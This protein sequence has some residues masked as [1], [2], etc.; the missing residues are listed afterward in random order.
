MAHLKFDVRTLANFGDPREVPTYSI[1]EA[2]HYLN[3]PVATIRAWVRGTSY[4]TAGGK[5]RFRRVIHV[6]NRNHP[7]LSFFNLAEAHVLRSLRTDYNVPLRH[8]RTALDYVKR[9]V[10]WSRPLIEERFQTDG[11][12]LFVERLGRL[13]D[14][15]ADGQLVIRGLV[16]SHLERLEW[17]DDLVARLY[18]FTSTQFV[19]A[20]KAVF[21]DPR[22]SFGRPVLKECG[23]ATAIIAERYK[24]GDSIKHLAKDYD[25]PPLEIEE[26]LRC[27]LDI[28][29]AA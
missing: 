10:G 24:A 11:V 3:I 7:F 2:A 6:P 23:I 12:S 1:S 4:N 28:R 22:Y 8:I 25:C 17:E 21:M 18:P 5:K 14:V 27:E 20:P 19:N 13:I 29:T 26:G 15:S 9:E 16:E